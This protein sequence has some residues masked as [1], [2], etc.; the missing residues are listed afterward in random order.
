VVYDGGVAKP[1]PIK[2]AVN[3]LK[4]RVS[5]AAL[6]VATPQFMRAYWRANAHKL[7]TFIADQFPKEVVGA[8]E[9]GEHMITVVH[10]LKRTAL[11]GP[12]REELPVVGNVVSIDGV[13]VDRG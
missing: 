8:G 5:D 12:P 4:Q 13:E 7:V 9:Q 6:D 1:D 11:D 10:A 2:Q 3:E